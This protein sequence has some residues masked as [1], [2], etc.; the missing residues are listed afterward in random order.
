LAKNQLLVLAFAGHRHVG[1]L[2]P[3]Y[4]VSI[5]EKRELLN[6]A[7]PSWRRAGLP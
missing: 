1:S 2:Q 3:Y 7:N 6:S 5:D 4:R